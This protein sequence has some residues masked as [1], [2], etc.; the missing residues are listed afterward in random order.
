MTLASCKREDYFE[1]Q[2]IT[3]CEECLLIFMTHTC[4]IYKHTC[5]QVKLHPY[6]L[7]AL[8][9]FQAYERPYNWGK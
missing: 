5:A 7:V 4:H 1:A 9:N 8:P 2:L 3:Y 6:L